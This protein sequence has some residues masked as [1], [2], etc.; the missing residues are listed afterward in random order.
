MFIRIIQE[1]PGLVLS[2]DAFCVAASVFP[3]LLRGFGVLAEV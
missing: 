3:A 1:F 2:S